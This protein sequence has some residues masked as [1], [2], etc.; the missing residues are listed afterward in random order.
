MGDSDRLSQFP[1]LESLEFELTG[2]GWKQC[3]GDIIL[4]SAGWIAVTIGEGQVIK[5][6]G[7]TPKG[8]GI[9]TRTPSLFPNAIN[10]RGRRSQKGNRT[11]F[12]GKK[13]LKRSK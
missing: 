2:I 7:H 8:K 6:Q 11:V 10:E 3:L 1:Q 13:T 9:Y 5:V 12:R 4:S